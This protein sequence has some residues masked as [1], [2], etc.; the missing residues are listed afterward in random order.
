MRIILEKKLL[1]LYQNYLKT[2]RL[3]LFVIQIINLFIFQII[4]LFVI[5]IIILFIF[6]IFILFI[7][8]KVILFIIQ[9]FILHIILFLLA[10]HPATLGH[11]VFK[12][13]LRGTHLRNTSKNGWPRVAGGQIIKTHNHPCKTTKS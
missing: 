9:K 11:P 5:Q 2:I 3:Y 1:Y 7:I 10:G 6:Q 8:Q 12:S 13:S 4:I